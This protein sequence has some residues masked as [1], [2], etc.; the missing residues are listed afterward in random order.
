MNTLLKDPHYANVMIIHKNIQIGKIIKSYG[1]LETK[2]DDKGLFIVC[3]IRKDLEIAN[4]I[5]KGI[6]SKEY[7]SFSIGCEVL[8]DHKE[9]D[10]KKCV[11]VLDK[12]NIFEVSVCSN[13]INKESG[14]V[15]INK[16][17]NDNLSVCK[18]CNYTKEEDS[19]TK[20]EKTKKLEKETIE[21]KD[22]EEEKVEEP[23]EEKSEDK[24]EEKTEDKT[25]ESTDKDVDA[26][27][28]AN[29][30][31]ERLEGLSQQINALEAAV[32]AL[33]QDPKEDDPEED[34]PEGTEEEDEE[35]YMSEDKAEKPPK[36]EEP[37]DDEEEKLP[38]E[39]KSETKEIPYAEIKKS[40][41]TIIEKIDN[42]SR[43][44]EVKTELKA[45]D[46]QL[47]ALSKK[48]EILSKSDDDEDEEEDE[49]EEEKPV[50]EKSAD[51]PEPKTVQKSED[52]IEL[53]E[54]KPI[55]VE[56]GIVYK[57]RD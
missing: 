14:F 6:V 38:E 25:E 57:S 22:D 24:N 51:K 53:E 28:K 48:I 26:E 29:S 8:K 9:C 52:E 21:E 47:N 37:V 40:L 30:I 43:I 50:E 36:E 33:L 12:I 16:S 34:T 3:E 27:E 56:K 4:E 19:M 20:E 5:W 17:Q 44:E 41:N 54:Y 42:L 11:T 49:K 23:K 2:V 10:D 35:E 31:D 15:I 46:D 32:Q 7:K 45:R 13:P 1:Q 55:V 18:E 39:E